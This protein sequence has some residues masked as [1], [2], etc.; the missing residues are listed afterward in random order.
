MGKRDLV[1]KASEYVFLLFKEK[2]SS[3]FVYHD[4]TH[5]LEVAE[6]CREIAE[7]MK[8]SDSDLEIVTLAG[9]FHDAGYVR[10]AEC[11]EEAGAEIAEEFLK[12]EFFPDEKTELVKKCILATKI[13]QR[14]G[15]LLEEIVCDADISHTGKKN[16]FERSDLL[17][18]EWGQTRNRFFSETEW[19]K[20][21][22]EFMNSHGFHTRYA[23][24]EFEGQRTANYIKLQRKIR[25]AQQKEELLHL[26]EDE[27]TQKHLQKQERQN[28]P[29]RGIE[30][31]FRITATNHIRLSSMADNKSH[32]MISVNTIIISIV[33]TLLVRKLDANPHLIIPTFL[34]LATSLLSIVFA[35]L[36][37]RPK[38]TS[39]TFTRE[40]I[41]EKRANLLFFGNFFNMQLDDFEWGMKEMMN[42]SDY[43]YG[44][45]IKDFY[46]L[47][48]VL[49]QKYRY[50]NICYSVFMFGMI[51]S[52]L[53]YFVAVLLYPGTDLNMLGFLSVFSK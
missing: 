31:M 35:T 53:A 44:S 5:S 52:V 17:R 1:K 26:K 41:K 9:W 40:D 25:K 15:G 7:G 2:L 34:L 51:I 21:N 38:I 28:K 29:E 48:K 6:T 14:P 32:I 13:P 22:E 33:I 4:Y 18:Y 3:E 49:G 20:L 46:F 10:Q 12:G 37:T 50:L 39:G 45:M 24:V 42:D 11:H 19:L 47:G 16:F 43:L 30:T 8:L 23:K 27:K 36:A